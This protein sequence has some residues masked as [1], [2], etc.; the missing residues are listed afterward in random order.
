MT[1]IPQ[2][3][4]CTLTIG[5]SLS[6]FDSPTFESIGD[7][8][9]ITPEYIVIYKTSPFHFLNDQLQECSTQ[10]MVHDLHGHISSS[11]KN[12]EDRY[13]S[14]YTT[15]TFP[16]SS[17][18]KVRFIHF[19]LTGEWRCVRI[20]GGYCIPNGRI[21]IVN[22]VIRYSQLLRSLSNRCVYFEKLDRH[23]ELGNGNS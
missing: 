7:E 15:S 20:S 21:D 6:I 13:L 9:I 19:N 22:G 8:T 12:T 4:W 18:A 14:C 11:F 10:D 1:R 2:F 17:P 3:H 5:E 23:E 16:F